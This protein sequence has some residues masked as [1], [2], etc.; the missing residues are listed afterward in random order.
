[1]G[2]GAAILVVEELEHARRRGA[3]RYCELRRIRRH[4]GRLPRVAAPAAGAEGAQRSMKAAM[5]DTGI[6]LDEVDYINAHRNV[7]AQSDDPKTNPPRSRRCSAIARRR[8]RFLRRS[9]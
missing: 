9:P 7:D 3:R 1:M 6:A 2:E 5:A 4:G 8:S